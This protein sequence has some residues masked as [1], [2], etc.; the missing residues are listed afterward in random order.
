M[1]IMKRLRMLAGLVAMLTLLA[2]IA[3]DTVYPEVSLDLSDK[4]ILVSLVSGLLGV[5]M[6]LRE[7][8]IQIHI[9][10]GGGDETDDDS[11]PR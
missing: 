10:G 5:D 6:A 2:L 3:A 7:F 4:I 1:T 8:P 9:D 11:G